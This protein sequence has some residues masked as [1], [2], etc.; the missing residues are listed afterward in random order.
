MGD[1]TAWVTDTVGRYR[2]KSIQAWEI[3]NEPSFPRDHVLCPSAESCRSGLG[4]M[5]R[6]TP[7]QLLALQDAAASIIK[8]LDPGALVVSPGVSYHH[9]N[10]LDH[11]LSIGG[12]RSADV[13]GYHLYLDGA[14]EL[15][16]SHV[17]G[18]R[19]IMRD[20]GVETKPLWN[21]ES[22]ISEINPD[23]DPAVQTARRMGVGAPTVSELGPAYLA[24]IFMVSW[25]SGVQRLYHY[26]WDD[27]HR[28]PSAHNAVRASDNAVIE[29]NDAGRAFVQ[30]RQWLVGRKLVSMETGGAGGLW[31][32]TLRASDGAVSYMV[33][34]PGRPAGAPASITKP[35]GVQRQCRLDGRCATV[36]GAGVSVDFRPTLLTP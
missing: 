11:Y 36:S 25:A 31:R 18:V 17:L 21:T 34:N 6:G 5:Y 1:W 3:W 26:A 15:M 32:A 27:Q 9:R 8:R 4:S 30:L 14:P 23:L 28:W 13:I 24:R 29:M 12:G 7:E 16:M 33:W 22:A 2:G 10:F 19:A 35:D 20:H